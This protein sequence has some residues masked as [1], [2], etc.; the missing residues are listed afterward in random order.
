MFGSLVINKSSL[1]F[2]PNAMDPLIRDLGSEGFEFVIPLDDIT[3]AALTKECYPPHRYD[4]YPE[5]SD[6]CAPEGS[7]GSVLDPQNDFRTPF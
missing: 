7:E 3:Y 1:T 2:K 4:M 6:M 5:Y